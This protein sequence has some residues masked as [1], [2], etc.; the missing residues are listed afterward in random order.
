MPSFLAAATSRRKSFSVPSAGWIA[1]CPPSSA[2]IAHGLPGSSAAGTS[3]L[4][5]PLRLTRPIGWIGGKYR[6]S[7]PSAAMRG[8]RASQSENVPC[9][10]PGGPHERGNISYQLEK[11]ARSGSTMTGSG[12]SSVVAER[13]SACACISSASSSPS[14]SSRRAESLPLA[15]STRAIS[16][17]RFAAVAAARFAASCTSAAPVCNAS[18]I[19][20]SS[21]VLRR[22]KSWRQDRNAST[23]AVTWYS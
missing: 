6:T 12:G 1:L 15:A 3:V 14:A 5:R 17:R 7:K 4:L 19:S 16:R 8:S 18:A 21:A 2:P 22:T 10:L 9:P 13:Q 23:H 20:A 11:R